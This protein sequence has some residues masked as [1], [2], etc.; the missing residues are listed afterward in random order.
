MPFGLV[1]VGS[2]AE[3]RDVGSRQNREGGTK[4]RA[5]SEVSGQH[6]DHIWGEHMA[7]PGATAP[8][9]QR[10]RRNR[11]VDTLADGRAATPLTAGVRGG[12]APPPSSGW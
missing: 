2:T 5:M 9:G 1:R 7:P 10:V 8:S 3:R 4:S 11:A 12:W 6:R